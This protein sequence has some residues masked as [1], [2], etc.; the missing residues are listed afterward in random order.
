MA[1]FPLGA[2]ATP[3]MW[4]QVPGAPAAREVSAKSPE[5]TEGGGARRERPSASSADEL[6]GAG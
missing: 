5:V 4:A 1:L 3:D 2:K 6:T